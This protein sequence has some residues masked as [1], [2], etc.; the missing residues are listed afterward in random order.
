MEWWV[1]RSFLQSITTP[2][3]GGLMV[4]LK[5]SLTKQSSP[6]SHGER[7][8]YSLICFPLRGRKT[9]NN[10]PYGNT[11]LLFKSVFLCAQ[12]LS[13]LPSRCR[14]FLFWPLSRKENI[15]SLC[16]LRVS[17][18]AGG[19][20]HSLTYPHSK[21]GTISIAWRF[22]GVNQSIQLNVRGSY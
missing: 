21:A 9:N 7:K 13:W 6:Q 14:S 19:E 20:K 3:K 10:K 15:F 17:S 11:D 8:V 12:R 16:E 5:G 18:E 4:T 2:K 1:W 22:K